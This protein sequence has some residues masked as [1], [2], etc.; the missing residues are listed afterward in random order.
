M[1]SVTLN[2]LLAFAAQAD[3]IELAANRTDDTQDELVGRLTDHLV[4]NLF[5]RVLKTMPS[6]LRTPGHLPI[7]PRNSLRPRGS[8]PSHQYSGSAKTVANLHPGDYASYWAAPTKL[9]EQP[10]PPRM[11]HPLDRLENFQPSGKEHWENKISDAIEQSLYM[12]HKPTANDQVRA[13][14]A[15]KLRPPAGLD[16]RSISTSAV[17]LRPPVDLAQPFLVQEKTREPQDDVKLKQMKDKLEKDFNNPHVL[18]PPVLPGVRPFA[19][20]L[21]RRGK[22]PPRIKDAFAKVKDSLQAVGKKIPGDYAALYMVPLLWASYGPLMR[23]I[24]GLDQPPEV[25]ALAAVRSLIIAGMFVLIETVQKRKSKQSVSNDGQEGVGTAVD[26]AKLGKYALLLGVL[27]FLGTSAQTHSLMTVEA[28]RSAFLVSIKTVLVPIVAAV[29]GAFSP[30]PKT[31]L[32]SLVA[33]TGT[34]LMLLS[35][36]GSGTLVPSLSF[37]DLESLFAALNFAIITVVWG[38]ALKTL[39]APELLSRKNAIYAGLCLLWAGYDFF[40]AGKVMWPVEALTNGNVWFG[41]ILSSLLPGF[42]SGLFQAKAQATI[43]PHKAQ[44]AYTL[45]PVFTAIFGLVLLH[46]KL[47]P[48]DALGA[49]MAVG[50][51]FLAAEKA[52]KPK[53]EKKESPTPVPAA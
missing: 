53:D 50:A 48:M 14:N 32:A 12:Y 19:P 52:T 27:N 13:Y 2:I 45:T 41:L 46:E 15:L 5:D 16:S 4:D 43:P 11:Y 35:K 30:T 34:S 18:G 37:G 9:G 20:A 39:P 51:S 24:Y 25:S 47:S 6:M 7:H 29:E 21:R 8:S 3:G 1:H 40:I 44:I 28:T 42:F 49:S 23:G 22:I 38:K 26:K 31:W 33:L 36:G 10:T 17:K